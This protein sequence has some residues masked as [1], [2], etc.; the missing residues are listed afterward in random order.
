M[1]T[2][3]QNPLI[4]T[5]RQLRQPKGRR[6][7]GRLLLEGTNLITAAIA[8]AHHFDTFLYT[9]AWQARHVD[10]WG[11][12]EARSAQLVAVAPEVLAAVATTVN[13]DG[14]IATLP[15]DAITAAPPANLRL[16]VMVERLQDPGNLGTL[17]RTA[18][19]T[20][21]DALWLSAESVDVANPKVLRASAGAWFTVPLLTVPD[22]LPVIRDYQQQGIQV[23]AT[24]PHT[25]RPYWDLDWTQPSLIVLGNESAGLSADILTQADVQVAIPQ[26]VQVESLNIAISG[27]LL[28]YEVQ[29]QYWVKA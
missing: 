24:T 13:P 10:L 25:A 7:Q 8:Q 9:A 19:A 11:A 6:E 16:G 1:I 3:R 14:A 20:Q 21:T 15:L 29:R 12:V 18:A 26:A 4:K 5:V 28:L 23:V 27:A 17:I 2:S 22:L